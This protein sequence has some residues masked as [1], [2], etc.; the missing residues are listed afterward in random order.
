MSRLQTVEDEPIIRPVS[1]QVYHL[2]ETQVRGVCRSIKLT[3]LRDAS[4]DFGIPNFVQLFHTRIEEDRGHEVS[5]LVL[6]NDHNVLIDSIWIKLQNGLLYYC[7]PFHCPTSDE[8]LGLDC[9]VEYTNANQ[10][11]M[12]EAPNIWVQYTHIEEN[13]IDNTFQGWIPSFPVLKFSWTWP[14]QNIQCQEHLPDGKAISTVS[15]RCNTTHQWVLH[16]QVQEYAVVF[17]TKLKD[18]HSWAD[19]VDRFIRVV[20]QTNMLHIV[21]VR[22]MVG[23]AHIVTEKAAASGIDCVWLLSIH[24]HFDTYRT[25]HQLDYNAWFRCVAV[26]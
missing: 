16:P 5:G 4:E 26:G 6:G 1:Q 9:K 15:K 23:P 8:R 10:G 12:P 11:V 13:D 19:C 7:Q 18:H 21:P 25:V 17:P 14:N 24:V 20:K 3:S 22:A 2:R